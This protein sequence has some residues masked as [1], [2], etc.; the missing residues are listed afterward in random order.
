LP[1]IVDFL[2]LISRTATT[3][4]VVCNVYDEKGKRSIT[5]H[6]V[7]TNTT[8]LRGTPIW[9]DRDGHP[10]YLDAKHFWEI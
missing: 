6:L 8:S 5:R 10:V 7:K 1:T 3:A 2:L 9:R 4:Q